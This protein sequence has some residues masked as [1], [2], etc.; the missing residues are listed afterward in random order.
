MRPDPG[1]TGVRDGVADLPL[2]DGVPPEI[3]TTVLADLAP[4]TFRP[5]QVLLREGDPGRAC[6]IILSGTVVATRRTVY[7]EQEVA[8]LGRGSIVGELAMLTRAPRRATVRARTEVR[9]LLAD[10][11]GFGRLL[12][13]PAVRDRL[14]LTAAQRLAANAAPVPVTLRDGT[15]AVLRPLLPTDRTGVAAGLAA[16]SAQSIRRR[17]FTD[18]RPSERL[19]DFLVDINYV[20]HF[21]WVALDDVGEPLGVGRYV[22]VDAASEDGGP[23]TAEVAF[24]VGDAVQDRGV[25]RLLLAA[26][27]PAAQVAGIEQF[28]ADVLYEN[29]PMRALLDRVGT[30]WQHSEPGVA[31]AVYP[32]A[33]ASALLPAGVRS[34]LRTVVADV[35]TVAVFGVEAD[36]APLTARRS[37]P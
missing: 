10:P 33:A 7:G 32:V 36:S 4:L 35:L 26:L 30:E 31:R 34:R 12:D 9:A 27:G 24:H 18:L 23:P 22:R 6:A 3:L 14:T 15:A 20:D 2:F 13:L 21:A 1:E 25:G 37:S 16:Q 28:R 29:A 11:V 17:F 19:I 8:V 5:G